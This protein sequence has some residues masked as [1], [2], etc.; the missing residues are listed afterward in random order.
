MTFYSD[1]I[2]MDLPNM[3]NKIL[4]LKGKKRR[5][6]MSRKRYLNKNMKT[7]IQLVK[8]FGENGKLDFKELQDLAKEE[9]IIDRKFYTHFNQ[10]CFQGY[11][12]KHKGYVQF[13]MDYD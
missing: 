1:L 3:K 7:I 11:I 4:K 12:K 8:T 6:Q 13:I 2:K 5:P 9:E 10:A